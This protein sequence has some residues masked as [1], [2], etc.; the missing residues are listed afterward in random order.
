MKKLLSLLL[1]TGTLFAQANN[2]WTINP[3]VY[4]ASIGNAG[5]ADANV[6]NLFHNP[7]FVGL[8]Q[9]HQEV[10][11]VDWLPNLTDDMGYS[12]I[13]YTS[14]LGF[15]SELFYFDYGTQ[16]QA[17]A[18]GIILGDFDSASYR[19]GVSYGLD[20][21]GWL[22][23]A[24]LNLYQH[25]FI[26]DID[27]SMNYGIDV[28]VHKQFNN[29]SLGIVLKDL[30]GD[31]EFL[32]QTLELP[33]S[34]GVGV[35]H[36]VAIKENLKYNLLLDVKMYE[37]WNSIGIGDELVINDMFYLRGGYYTEAE[38]DVDYITFG[39][40]IDTGFI[41][42]DLAYLFNEESFHNETL[43]LSFGFDF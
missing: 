9:S 40:G 13:Q 3:S 23:G 18:G 27:I 10:T 42:I 25:N 6:K 28:G 21:K 19:I 14:N 33:M 22:F 41:N 30:G 11:Y 43:M 32:E 20:L 31:T 8:K 1:L 2:I 29:T 12:N 37:N 7:A 15:G 38:F 26:D 36:S 5:I 16:T 39:G 24:R 17:D 35:K 4:S 34:I